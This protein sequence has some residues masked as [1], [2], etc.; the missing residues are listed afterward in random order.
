MTPLLL[1]GDAQ[2]LPLADHSVHCVVTSPPYWG[3]RDYGT[4][5]WRGGDPACLHSR[6]TSSREATVTSE[7][8]PANVNHAREP[9][10]GGRC[11][12]CGATSEDAQLGTESLH[13]CL[14]WARQEP[15]CGQCYVCSMRQTF[16]E[17]WRV[18]R[19]DGTCWVVIGDSYYGNGSPGGDATRTCN[20]APN[21]MDKV[22]T[23]RGPGLKSKD[24]AGI[25][26][27]VA[28]ALQADGWVLR[29]DIIWSKANCMPESVTDRP[30]RAHEYIFLLAKQARY[31][32]DQEAVREVAQTAE[33]SRE[34]NNGESA[35]D[36]KMRGHGSSCGTMVEGRN[37]RSVWTIPTEAYS[38]AH[39][40]TFPQAL[41]ERCIKAGT[42]EA[43]CCRACGA[44]WT[45]QTER[46]ETRNLS[47]KGSRFDLGKTGTNGQ[48][49]VQ[50]GERYL[51]RSTGFAPSCL[52]NSG[53]PGPC[54]VLDPF[55]GTGTTLLVA[56]ALR[57]QS[58]GVD[59]SMA[60][61]R[62]Q[63]RPRLQLDALAA[64]EGNLVRAA[65]ALAVNDLPL[66]QR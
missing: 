11:G 4:A 55:C 51:S 23:K 21:A 41:V 32:W 25:P 50:A 54:T 52:C 6:Q 33:R 2:A 63:A 19:P 58:V 9:W 1:Q 26:W 15:P 64:W 18:L 17:V 43:G 37:L 35:V 7:S 65:P 61:L 13:D 42:S 48:S 14:A 59:L 10:E 66:F 46:T 22:I 36:T 62:H 16:R 57:R 49:R 12:R 27:R 34:K 20:S 8:R 56:R 28:L 5:T 40:A 47:A 31:F 38:G 44:P 3:L 60:Y 39:F 45:R 53:P 24:L 29:S 30:T